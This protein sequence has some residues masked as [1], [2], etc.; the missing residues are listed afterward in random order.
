MYDHDNAPKSWQSNINILIIPTLVP[1][2]VYNFRFI[3]Y[4]SPRA[5]LQ[6][7]VRMHTVCK[8]DGVTSAVHDLNKKVHGKLTALQDA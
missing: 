3:G 6:G 5:A 1:N 7:Y 8:V 2:T 4:I